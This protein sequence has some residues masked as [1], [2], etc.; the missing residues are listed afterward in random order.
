MVGFNIITETKTET[1]KDD[2]ESYESGELTRSI[3][4]RYTDDAIILQSILE[5]SITFETEKYF[6]SQDI[7]EYHLLLNCNYYTELY[8]GDK[9]KTTIPNRVKYIEP[10]VTRLLKK[11]VSLELIKFNKQTKEYQFT[12]LGRLLGFLISYKKNKGNVSGLYDHILVFYDSMGHSYAKLCSIFFRKIYNT[13]ILN[14]MLDSLVKLLD[15]ADDNKELFLNQIKNMMPILS[16]ETW[17]ILYNSFA[18][19]QIKDAAKYDVLFYNFKLYLERIHE[20]KSRNLKAFEIKRFSV[21]YEPFKVALEGYCY[22]CNRYSIAESNLINYLRSFANTTP[23]DRANHLGAKCKN[24]E[25]NNG[26]LDFEYIGEKKVIEEIPGAIITKNN[27]VTF[28][29]LD[30]EIHI[31]RTIFEQFKKGNFTERSKIFQ[32]ILI[33]LLENQNRF[34]KKREIQNKVIEERKE[35]FDNYDSTSKTKNK[36]AADYFKSFTQCLQ[37][38]NLFNLVEV[39]KVQSKKIKSLMVDEYHISKPGKYIALV[40]KTQIDEQDSQATNDLIYQHWKVGFEDESFSLDLFCKSYFKSCLESNVLK[41]FIKCYVDYILEQSDLLR[42]TELFSQM[43]FYRFYGNESNNKKLWEFW[44]NSLINLNEKRNYFFNH[45]KLQIDRFIENRV[46]NFARYEDARY[47]NR[48]RFKFVTI[49]MACQRCNNEYIYL[50]VP[51]VFYL[52]DFFYRM[53]GALLEYT[54]S[55]QC[56]RCNNK[57]F[58]FILI[59][60]VITTCYYTLSLSSLSS[61]SSLVLTVLIMNLPLSFNLALIICH[62]LIFSIENMF[63]FCIIY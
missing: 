29:S 57:E 48:N 33:F 46:H 17:E 56:K 38:L 43:I 25:C 10:R 13:P 26:F 45:I 51:I 36:N 44:K 4:P 35:F 8:T 14:Q 27:S 61:K 63:L 20:T 15:T 50:Q 53:P 60:H 49:E 5:Y 6:K 2:N 54:N 41:D 37:I 12:L 58:K 19:L 21:R 31:T 24:K 3:E 9:A 1:V 40:A 59:Y 23:K 30:D 34:Y 18:E 55:L 39:K 52:R 42:Y 11:L 32:S 16:K 22:S 47:E 7:C 62:H 28:R